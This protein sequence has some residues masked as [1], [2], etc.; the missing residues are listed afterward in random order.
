MGDNETAGEA[1]PKE[2]K[3]ILEN[4]LV[5][6][7]APLFVFKGWCKKCGICVGLCPHKA[8]EWGEDGY[9]AVPSPDKCRRCNLCEYRCPDF[10]IT[11]LQTRK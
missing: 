1:T 6:P 11:L 4:K 9:P 7:D 10:A 8:F 5:N 3:N 2:V